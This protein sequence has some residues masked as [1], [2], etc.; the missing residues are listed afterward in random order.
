MT[1]LVVQEVSV[2]FGSRVVLQDVSFTMSAGELVALQGPSGSGKSC[3]LA[4]IGGLQTPDSGSVTLDGAPVLLGDDAQRRQVGLMLQG[5]GLLPMLTA[6]ENIEV[7]LQ[8]A[9][10]TLSPTEVIASSSAALARVGLEDRSDR[11]V[12]EL[13]GGQRQRVALARAVVHSPAL[14]LADEPTSALDGSL[15]TL[16]VELLRAEADRGAGVIVATHD[17]AVVGW[18]DRVL[19]LHD[20]ALVE[21]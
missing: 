21:G 10:G 4:V 14:V 7:P 15:R 17:P 16:A 2:A 11:L 6:A 1:L 20:G 8:V 9:D 18:A 13:S 12:E 3:L 19:L 5:L